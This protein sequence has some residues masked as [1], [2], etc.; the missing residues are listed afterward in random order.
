[1]VFF[2]KMWYIYIGMVGVKMNKEIEL[3]VKDYLLKKQNPDSS[4]TYYFEYAIVDFLIRLYGSINIMNPYQLKSDESLKN[5]L[6]IYGASMEKVNELFILLDEYGNWLQSKT[7]EKNGVVDKI[8]NILGDLVKSKRESNTISEEDLK[9]F[10]SFFSLKDNKLRALVDMI[11]EN[12]ESILSIWPNIIKEKEPEKPKEESI[13]LPKEKYEEYGIDFEEVE[14]LTQEK[15]KELNAEILKRE[16]NDN[17]GGTTKDKPLKLV[18]SSGN[19]FVDALVLLS[20]MCTEI[21]L[22]VIVT[23][24]L[25]RL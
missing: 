12:K 24:I 11:S 1:M 25:A 2:N 4:V 10:E 17:P 16:K 6:V 9:Y 19:G 18:L 20:I 5:N 22:G 15:V 3:G 8:F 13:Y 7:K 23:I 14:K 21:M